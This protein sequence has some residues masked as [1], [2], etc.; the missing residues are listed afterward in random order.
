MADDLLRTRLDDLVRRAAIDPVEPARALEAGRRARR[1][2]AVG[3]GAALA[4]PLA[5]FAVVAG[6]L[7]FQSRTPSPSFSDPE[8]RVAAAAEGGSEDG[9]P[10]LVVSARG[11]TSVS[12]TGF[13]WP[14][15]DQGVVSDRQ[16]EVSLPPIDRTDAEVM[17]LPMLN[18]AA[19]DVP[20]VAWQHSGAWIDGFPSRAGLVTTY[21]AQFDGRFFYASCT[22]PGDY[23]PA[24]RPRLADV[25]SA[26]DTRGLLSHCSYLG[27]VDF[28]AWRV[29]ASDTRDGTVAALLSAPDGT[30]A[31][32]V[33]SQDERRRVVQVLGEASG[34]A[35]LYGGSGTGLLS[36]VGTT[37]T[38]VARLDVRSG[39]SV[40]RVPVDDGRYATLVPGGA[41]SAVTAY[42]ADGEV[43]AESTGGA[44]RPGAL[45]ALPTECFTT[46]ETAGDGC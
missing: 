31:R 5:V 36:V 2:R 6:L 14:I 46:V 20:D 27:H 41:V 23:T 15:E 7:V 21:E 39:G 37:G 17:C 11:R 19:P 18:Q 45:L 10:D 24:R 26:A 44:P 35:V 40:H 3:R 34:D 25:P 8:G 43:V 4:T 32:C 33:L 1:R 16:G 28:R 13:G 9:Y 29:A 42:D 30:D 22:L 38:E 12:I